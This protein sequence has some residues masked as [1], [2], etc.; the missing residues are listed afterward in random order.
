MEKKITEKAVQETQPIDDEFICLFPLTLVDDITNI[1]IKMS[2]SEDFKILY[3]V[4]GGTDSKNLVKR[5]LERIF[6]NELAK[7]CLWTGFGRDHYTIENNFKLKDL[8]L[9]RYMLDIARAKFNRTESD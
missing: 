8:K 9:M 1:E 4:I 2:N 7:R 3:D 6:S 5:L